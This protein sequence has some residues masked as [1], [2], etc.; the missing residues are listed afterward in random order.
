[1]LVYVIN[2]HGNQLMPCKPRKARLL[3]EEGKA[4]VVKRT[5]F[6]I[7]LLYG[8]AG[9]K[10]PVMLGVDPGYKYAG[11]SA[12]TKSKVL[13][14]IEVALRTDMV[15]LIATRRELRGGRRFRKTRFR[16]A[17]FLNR[18]KEEGWLAPSVENRIDAHLKVIRMANKILPIS[19]VTIET[20][21]F[22]IQKINNSDITGVEYQ[23]GEQLGFFNVREYVLWRDNHTCCYCKGKNK[24]SI[25]EVHHIESRKTGG[26]APGN[27]ITL[28]KTCHENIHLGKIALSEKRKKS[29]KAA[30][31][32]GIVRWTIYNKLKEQYG[33]VNLTYGYITK[34]TRI[35][36]GLVKSHCVD[37]RCISGN[38]NA[39]PTD[40][41]YLLKQVRGQNRKLHK[42]QPRKGGKRQV[43]Q[44]PRYI[45]GYQ[46]YDKVLYKGQ[47]CFIHGRRA[48]GYFDLRKLENNTVIH[49]S[50]SYK[51]LR[52]LEKRTTMLAERKAV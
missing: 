41:M 42:T 33:N 48:T 36:A 22:D 31:F 24:D 46:R 49:K 30:A 15:N 14:E 11:L 28:C 38:P 4:K 40:T 7:Q 50:A 23:Q 9:Y 12:T 35:R 39:I 5:P 44:G 52:L 51:E 21:Q 45:K 32:M 17:R 29:Y 10:Q 27:L 34:D 16:K 25:L 2:K 3:L 43:N 13:L 8:S 1:M 26:N 37:A 18:K 20:A 19:K 47:E 6:T